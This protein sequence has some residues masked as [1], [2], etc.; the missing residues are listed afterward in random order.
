M[1]KVLAIAGLLA[2]L[3]VPL[4]VVSADG[5]GHPDGP[6][7]D[8]ICHATGNDGWVEVTAAHNAIYGQAGHF[9]EPGTTSAGHEDDYEGP[10]EEPE[11][12]EITTQVNCT[13]WRVFYD[14]VKM[15][16][17]FWTLPFELEIAASNFYDGLIR[18]PERCLE[19]PPPTATP[20]PIRLRVDCNGWGLMQGDKLIDSGQWS[21]PFSLEVAAS[22]Y[23]D[24]LIREPE[25]CLRERGDVTLRIGGRCTED[26]DSQE[27]G[28]V[29]SDGDFDGARLIITRSDGV[30]VANVG[31]GSDF[32]PARAAVYSWQ[33][34][35]FNGQT[36]EVLDAGRFEVVKCD[37]VPTPTPTP[38]GDCS[39]TGDNICP[40]DD[41]PKTGGGGSVLDDPFVL[42]GGAIAGLLGIGI[43]A[44]RLWER[45]QGIG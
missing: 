43:G 5:D 21:D 29:F 42:V 33:I 30:E 13:G 22:Q 15:D 36:R 12:P 45:K 1:R 10:C 7:R 3:A 11:P 39:N 37:L 40:G 24:Y 20:E 16:E 19:E 28:Y 25:D 17:G 23:V 14:D 38:E 41:P 8:T 35:W 4:L 6:H 18:E 2:L 44:L 27:I 32:F 34:V 9:S 31:E 26:G